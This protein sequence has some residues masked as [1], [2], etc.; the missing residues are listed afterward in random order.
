[1]K[2]QMAWRDD[3]LRDV[4]AAKGLTEPAQ[5]H[6]RTKIPYPQIARYTTPKGEPGFG[7]P[8]IN[9]LASIASSLELDADYLL[10]S[11]PRYEGMTAAQ[12]AAH[13]ALDRYVT[14]EANCGQPISH[15]DHDTLRLIATNHSHPPLWVEDW[16]RVHESLRLRQLAA[17]PPGQP[18][19]KGPS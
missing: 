13:M 2:S 11:D 15:E 6:H 1:M 19:S 18:R 12:A 9:T 17:T 5:F 8:D 7:R 4:L 3:R 14:D 16:R 10:E